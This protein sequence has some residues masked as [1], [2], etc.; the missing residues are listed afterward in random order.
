MG[1]GPGVVLAVRAWLD[2]AAC[3]GVAGA[4][5]GRSSNGR[6]P[7][8]PPAPA[9]DTGVRVANAPAPGT[10]DRPLPRPARRRCLIRVGASAPPAEVLASLLDKATDASNAAV[11]ILRGEARIVMARAQQP[12]LENAERQVVDNGDTY[13]GQLADASARGWACWRPRTARSGRRV[14]DNALSGLGVAYQSNGVRYEG[15]WRDGHPQGWA[16]REK[17]SS[18]RAEGNFVAGHL[19]GFGL[20][21]S[22]ADRRSCRWANGTT[23]RSTARHRD[24]GRQGTLRRRLPRRQASTV[25]AR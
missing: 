24:G 1:A 12:G 6:A 4:A 15:Q 3:R 14:E 2:S 19:E 5:R 22:F 10:H 23:I 20:R 7:P 13:I 8:P 21:R 17:W 18:R 16:C 25:S 11:A 9:P